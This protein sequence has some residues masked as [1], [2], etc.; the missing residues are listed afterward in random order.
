[1]PAAQFAVFSVLLS[2]QPVF[3]DL[4]DLVVRD[5]G[6]DESENDLPDQRAAAADRVGGAPQEPR[7]QNEWE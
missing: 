4:L 7:W 3:P 1:M 5:E 6:G 2:H